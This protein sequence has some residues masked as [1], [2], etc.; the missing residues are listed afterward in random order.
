MVTAPH[1]RKPGAAMSRSFGYLSVLLALG[2]AGCV[3]GFLGDDDSPTDPP[4]GSGTPSGTQGGTTGVPGSPVM[5]GPG[6]LIDGTPTSMPGTTPTNM[7]AACTP[8]PLSPVPRIV[9]LTRIQYENSV[10]DLTGLDVRPAKDLPPDTTLLG[11]SRNLSLEVGDLVGRVF[12]EQAASVARQVAS[13]PANIAKVVSCDPKTGDACATTF[14]ADFGKRVFRRPLTDAEKMRY[15]ALFKQGNTVVETGD[16]FTKGVQVTLEAMLQSPHFLYRF[17]GSTQKDG[18]HVVLGSY[19]IAS[20][21]SYMLTNSTPDVMLL[22]AAEKD[23]LRDV[24]N[25]VTQARRLLETP[26]G[27][28]MIRD[29][30]GQW[31]QADDW[32]N[33]ADKNAMRYPAWKPTLLPTLLEE[34]QSF[35]EHTVFT[36]KK[37][38]ATLMTSTSGFVNKA[39]APIY[40]VMGTFGDAV[41]RVDLNPAQRA[42]ILTQLG[43]LASHASSLTSSPIHRGVFV[44]RSLLC[45][46]IPPPGEQVPPLPPTSAGKTTR[47]V[48]SEH[49]D[50]AGCRAC[51]H[52]LI[53]PVGFG[54]EN[55]DAIGAWRTME[56]GKPIDPTG[57]L[58]GTSKALAFSNPIDMA[59]AIVDSP[60]SRLC[61]AK[62]WLRYSYGREETPGDTCALETLAQAIGN[63]SYTP[64]ELVLDMVRSRAFMF[65]SAEGL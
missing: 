9:R 23:E 5:P 57:S 39:T 6:G 36:Q 17:E 63:D 14:I 41:T 52:G 24:N 29:F 15:L 62:Q 59:K 19:D 54:L 3:G 37:G 1:A 16:A 50:A 45:T 10:R 60:E 49:T 64:V 61:F 13:A 40:G 7:P 35:A 18:A 58:V 56:N 11:F 46:T 48:V 28:A 44:Q 31:M 25:V 55:Y 65:R 30:F 33:H 22:A 34:L 21:L 43:F 26:A 47:E 38:L 12:N 8:G 27:K 2:V 4:P 42:G 20:R 51:H 53:N 32:A